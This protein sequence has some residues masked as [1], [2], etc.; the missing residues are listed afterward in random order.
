MVAIPY[1]LE[2]LMG[3]MPELPR[4]DGMELLASFQV[5]AEANMD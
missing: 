4:I 5:V 1:T 3:Y 2:V